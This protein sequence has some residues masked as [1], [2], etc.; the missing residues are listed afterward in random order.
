MSRVE[1]S[2]LKGL[3]VH[4]SGQGFIDT[5]LQEI[6]ITSGA[7]NAAETYTLS[8]T[9][10]KAAL[11]HVVVSDNL[12]DGTAGGASPAENVLVLPAAATK[13]QIKVVILK[14]SIAGAGVV[15][16]AAK[17]QGKLL[18]KSGASTIATL[19]SVADTANDFAICVYNGSAWLT[20]FST[21]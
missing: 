17:R 18:I 15:D 11:M 14:A 7:D 2:A 5:N 16:T 1:L 4:K 19:Q 8:S 13:G 21:L 3:T 9:A 10:E 6:T 20:G 12:A